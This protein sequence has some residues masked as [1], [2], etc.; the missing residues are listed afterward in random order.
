MKD[1]SSGRLGRQSPETL[2]IDDKIQ[3]AQTEQLFTQMRTGLVGAH[4]V[5]AAL[6]IGLWNVVPRAW[7]VA[8]LVGYVAAQIPR[9]LLLRRFCGG[10]TGDLDVSRSQNWFTA[11]NLISALLWGLAAVLFF[12]VPSMPHEFL[13]AACVTGIGC[14]AAA[15]CWPVTSVYVRTIVL[16]LTPLSARFL[17]EGDTVHI[18]VGAMVLVLTG[19]LLFVA[20]YMNRTNVAS[21]RLRFENEA[22]IEELSG[23]VDIRKRVE[24][25]LRTSRDD[26]EVR[27]SERTAQLANANERLIQEIAERSRAETALQE[28][29]QKYR[30]LAE[31]LPQWVFEIDAK[32]VF[33]FINKRGLEASRYTKEDLAKGINVLEVIIPE[34]V[35]RIAADIARVMAGERV[36][37]R[38]Y[39]HLR[40]DG[41]TVTVVTESFPVFRSNEVTGIRGIAVDIEQQKQLERL[42]TVQRDLARSLSSLSDLNEALSLCLQTALLV[43]GMDIAGTYLMTEDSG[44]ELVV[45]RGLSDESVKALSSI[46]PNSMQ[47]TTMLRGQPAYCKQEELGPDVVPIAEREGI[48]AAGIIPVVHEGKVIAC[49]IMASRGCDDVPLSTRRTLEAIAGQIGSAITRIMAERKLQE[50]EKMLKSILAT[51]PIGIGLMKG[52]R[53]VWVNRSWAEM[54][55]FEKEEEESLGECSRILYPSEDAYARIGRIFGEVSADL[56]AGWT[57]EV[58][59]KCKRKDGSVFDALIRVALLDCADPGRGIIVAIS[60]ISNRKKTEEALRESEARYRILSEESVDGVYIVERTTGTLLEANQSLLDLFGYSREELVGTGVLKLYC[61]RLDQDRFRHDLEKR[62]SR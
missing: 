60:D 24:E 61:D 55:G 46:A 42:L 28:S 41:T 36:G 15:V 31:L 51:S 21:L 32:G 27:V 29:E 43:S 2:A 6:T 18:I 37:P 33:T 1:D 44:F 34:D 17:Y 11:G 26:L 5:A 10:R 14:G 57:A 45:H 25:E 30:E 48:R 8:W 53:I 4:I 35:S 23:H 56:P 39:T 3:K 7:L 40:K 22:L 59:A 50:S 38:E 13:L 9:H 58:D 20:R 54:F 47:A 62:G 52:R 49:L 12:P 16:V 19:A